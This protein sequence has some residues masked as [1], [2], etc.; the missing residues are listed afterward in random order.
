MNIR[1][2]T[3]LDTGSLLVMLNTMH[4]EPEHELDRVD[5]VKVSHTLVDCIGKGLVLIAETDEGV[6]AG[7][8]GG[9]ISTEWY[10]SA[11]LLGDYWYYVLPEHRAS[12]AAFQLM[13]HFEKLTE[14]NVK[15][16]HVLGDDIERK[17]NMFEKLGFFK[18]GSLYR[19]DQANGRS[20]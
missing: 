10:S 11:P 4:Q 16:G 20:M 5:W 14:M 9:D 19:K 3:L 13:K 12:P 7:S 17:D 18:S 6:F 15:V 2:A 1:H 8:I